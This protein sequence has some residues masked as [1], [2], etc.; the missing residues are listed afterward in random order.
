M[1]WHNFGK[2][3]IFDHSH[4]HQI[5]LLNNTIQVALMKTAYTPNIDTHDFWTST[6]VSTNE[7][8][9]TGYT[10]KGATLASKAINRDDV[11]D[12]S[13]FDAGDTVFASIG[14]GAN[15]TFDKIL[16]F[17]DLALSPNAEPVLGSQTV[18]STTT[19]GG[20]ITLVW[21]PQGILQLA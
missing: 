20:D 12:R 19:N 4:A 17:A 18:A 16:I 6:G 2:L 3:V 14:N 9:A 1:A 8:V 13:E 15:D 11:N 5:D 21:D 7:I 10:A